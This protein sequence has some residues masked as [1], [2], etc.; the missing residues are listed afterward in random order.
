MKIPTAEKAFLMSL[1]LDRVPAVT[2]NTSRAII[3]ASKLKNSR[4]PNLYPRRIPPASSAIPTTI[5]ERNTEAAPIIATFMDSLLY[6]GSS[7]NL[8]NT[9]PNRYEK[10][11]NK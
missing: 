6:S 2:K 10:I 8:E 9:R 4:S 5:I 1:I 3:N 11:V 7:L